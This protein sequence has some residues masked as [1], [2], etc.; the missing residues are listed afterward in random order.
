MTI[1][2]VWEATERNLIIAV[3]LVSVTGVAM[4]LWLVELSDLI[5]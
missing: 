1:L 2:V 5:C 3:L 4:V